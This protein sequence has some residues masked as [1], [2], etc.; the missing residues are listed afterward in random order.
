MRIKSKLD[1]I[2]KL[3]IMENKRIDMIIYS[4]DKDFVEEGYFKNKE[5]R[6]LFDNWYIDKFCQKQ[7]IDRKSP[8]IEIAKVLAD[9]RGLSQG[10]RYCIIS[11]KTIED[12]LN[13]FREHLLK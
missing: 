11:K 3:L 2:E 5:E 4:L 9:K 1:K 13:E 8:S 6:Q 12:N 10:E 7:G